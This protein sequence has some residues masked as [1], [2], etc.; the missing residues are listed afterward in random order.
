MDAKKQR[1]VYQARTMERIGAE[2]ECDL[3]IIIGRPLAWNLHDGAGFLDGKATCTR[4]F[5][6]IPPMK[7]KR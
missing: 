5:E 3:F 1:R 2:S 7:R 4:K 6:G